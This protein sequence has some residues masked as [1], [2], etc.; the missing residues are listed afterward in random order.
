MSYDLYF[1]RQTGDFKKSPSEVLDALSEDGPVEGIASFPRDHV[2]RVLKEYFPEIEDADMELTWEGDG[3]YFQVSFGHAT[4]RDVHL[5]VANCGY[6]LLKSQTA[7]NRLIEACTSIG[8]A[9]YD[10]QTDKRF[11]QPEPKRG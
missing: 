1:W 10:P 11:E 6:E 2:R 9:L 3:S 4:E 5:I 7:I 8:C